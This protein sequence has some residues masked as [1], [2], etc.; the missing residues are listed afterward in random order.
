MEDVGAS[1]GGAVWHP[2]RYASAVL[3][4]RMWARPARLDA[5]P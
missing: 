5:R 3:D 4:A 1:V 2:E